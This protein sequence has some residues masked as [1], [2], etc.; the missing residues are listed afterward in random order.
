MS[1]PVAV[2]GGRPHRQGLPRSLLLWVFLE[3]GLVSFLAELMGAQYA[4]NMVGCQE[5]TIEHKINSA[6]ARASSSS[7]HRVLIE[8]PHHVSGKIPVEVA[9]PS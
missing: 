2:V 6:Y 8:S 5:L 1:V 9:V 3:V 4:F 7:L